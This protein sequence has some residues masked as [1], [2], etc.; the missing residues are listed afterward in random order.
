VMVGGD[1]VEPGAQII[2]DLFHHPANQRLQ[3]P[4]IRTVLGRN[5]EP[6]L[7]RVAAGP[8]EEGPAV[9]IILPGGI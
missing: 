9:G 5:N 4:V 6:E 3:I 2:L 7:V 8:L 1:P